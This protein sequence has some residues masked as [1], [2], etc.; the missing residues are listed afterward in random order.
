MPPA[1]TGC[2]L[3]LAIIRAGSVLKPDHRERR[4]EKL[5][6][7]LAGPLM[8][9]APARCG[10]VIMSALV[11]CLSWTQRIIDF[12]TDPTI[13]WVGTIAFFDR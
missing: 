2:A 11:D 5:A 13:S 9:L 4:R 7:R 8:S 3:I 10:I 6:G 12:A 1:I